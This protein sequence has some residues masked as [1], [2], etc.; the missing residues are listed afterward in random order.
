[1]LVQVG[2]QSRADRY[3]YLPMIG[4]LTAIAFGMGRQQVKPLEPR[5]AWSRTA[6]L[7]VGAALLLLAGA[8]W[9]QQGYWEN[10]LPLWARATKIG[11]V[12]AMI[13]YQKGQACQ[14]NGNL[15]AAELHYRK[16]I[17]L[18]PDYADALVNLG[19]VLIS[20]QMPEEAVPPLERAVLLR[21]D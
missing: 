3:T 8:T 10:S 9:Q 16:A 11:G 2:Y 20:R 6:A 5:R 18:Y 14:T 21:P 15:E 1:G 4:V 17:N 13:E 19:S 7:V 12:D